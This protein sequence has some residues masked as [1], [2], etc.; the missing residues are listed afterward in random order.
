MKKLL[1]GLIAV[2]LAVIPLFAFAEGAESQD[3]TDEN[4]L[5]L[6]ASLLPSYSE[7]EREPGIM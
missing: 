6:L 4:A 3:L 5:A 7:L 1:I 2:L